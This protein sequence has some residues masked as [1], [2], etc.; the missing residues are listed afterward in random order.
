MR[1][2]GSKACWK[3]YDRIIVTAPRAPDSV[4]DC[5]QHPA[6]FHH[7]PIWARQPASSLVEWHFTRVCGRCD[8]ASQKTGSH[9]SDVDAVHVLI[10]MAP[11]RLAGKHFHYPSQGRSHRSLLSRSVATYRPRLLS[12]PRAP[13]TLLPG[14]MCSPTLAFKWV[15]AAPWHASMGRACTCP[16]PSLLRARAMRHRCS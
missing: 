12:P 3:C 6:T 15:H 7:Q 13:P 4:P 2:S 14:W 5:R 16:S 10:A 8:N 11:L 9:N 1:S